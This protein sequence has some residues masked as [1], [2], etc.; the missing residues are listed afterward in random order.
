MN[1]FPV[2]L[3]LFVVDL[4]DPFFIIFRDLP[5]PGVDFS[6]AQRIKFTVRENNNCDVIFQ[7]VPLIMGVPF[8]ARIRDD[9]CVPVIGEISRLE[10]Q[11]IFHGFA[12]RFA[13]LS[14]PLH[15]GGFFGPDR[16]LLH[17]ADNEH[18]TYYENRHD[19]D[20]EKRFRNIEILPVRR[21]VVQQRLFLRFCQFFLIVLIHIKMKKVLCT[22]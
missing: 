5:Q 15:I 16:S 10:R 17:C 14:K 1:Q 22:F 9:H 8:P 6:V 20:R 4:L 21:H 18:N 13:Q 7:S 2:I 12:E 3:Q 11:I 19:E